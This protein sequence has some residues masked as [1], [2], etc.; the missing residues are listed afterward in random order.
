MDSPREKAREQK[1]RRTYSLAL[2]H[3]VQAVDLILLI[4]LGLTFSSCG[5]SSSTTSQRG[6]PQISGNWQFTM[7]TTNVSFVASPLQGGF[8]LQKNGAIT[9]QIGFSIVLPSTNGGANATCN[10]GTAAVTGTIGGQTV[11]LTAAIGALDAKGAPTTQTLTL[12]GGIL[13]SDGKAIQSGTYTLTAADVL[14]QGQNGQPQLITCGG[15][16]Q[17]VGTWSATLVP[18]LTGGF[19]GF[20]HSANGPTNFVNQN[21]PV[22]GTFTQGP[23][24]GAASATVT[25][26]LLFQDPVT[27]LNNY[28]C[29]TTASVNG[30]I[31]GNTIL[32][33]IFSTS[34]TPV[35]QIGQTPGSPNPTAVTFDS[36]PGGYVVHN[37]NGANAGQ[38]GG[39]YAVT[40]KSCALGDSGNLCL[41]LGSTKACNQPVL[42]TPFSLTFPPQLV[43]SAATSQTVTL[44]NTSGS[45]LSGLTLR[46]GDND[47]LLFYGAGGDF[48]GAPNFTEQDNCTQQ[49]SISLDSGASCTI[50]VFF[51]PQE[52][53]PWLPQSQGAAILGLPPAQCPVKLT[54]GLTI[55]VPKG[56]GDA[57]TEFS[58]PI[59]GTGLSAVVPSV[60]EIDFGAQALGEASG[61]QTLTFTNQ[62]SKPVTILP[63]MA[64][65]FSSSIEPAVPRPPM[66]G[67]QPLVAGLQLAE[68]ANIGLPNSSA[69]LS[70][71]QL[72]PPLVNAPTVAYFCE[73]DP[74]KSNGGSGVP[75]FRISKDEC[76]GQTLAPFGQSGNSCSLQITFV[77]QPVTWSAAVSSGAGLDDF[78]QLNTMW[79]G[80]AS[81][82]PEPNCEVDSGRFPVEI[83]T[84]APSSLRMS[85]SAGMDF[86]SVIKGT[87]SSPLTITLFND[88]VDPAAGT[89]TFTSKLV[90]G[91]D[92]TESD[93]CPA[94][95]PSNQSCAI[96]VVFTPTI[97]GLDGGKITFTYSTSFNNKIE[98]GLTQTI[99][100]RGMGQ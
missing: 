93:T 32:L 21:F 92:Y 7:S 20:F 24:I 53:C 69:I 91:A 83:K 81:N 59:S 27:L 61:P 1:L 84:N 5:G 43:G 94:A 98:L 3:H 31:S 44:S 87:A 16:S 10:S 67:G 49:G 55:T 70:Q 79:C 75:N 39:G 96:T 18:P 35:G 68:T 58:L 33:K 28:P 17:D 12:S 42:L 8:L 52:S 13:S 22:S 74:P 51:S 100:L 14:V 80:D 47:S 48:N 57:N 99:Y 25:G 34:G 85:P 71:S 72:A 50:T 73:T 46:F 6:D 89:V 90:S 82:P 95:L 15:G 41:A 26:T 64:C 66:S 77:P 45:A 56:S 23:N 60:P 76:S 37:L 11:S 54:A 9:G 88:P 29:L 19:E 2:E 38:T 4:V 78:L 97:V 63:A 40:T 86:G 36:T 65:A 62:S 30:T